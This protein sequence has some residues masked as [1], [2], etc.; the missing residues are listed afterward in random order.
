MHQRLQQTAMNVN[1]SICGDVT[2]HSRFS[3]SSTLVSQSW[4]YWR[5]SSVCD[6]SKLA[7]FKLINH[8][9]QML[10]VYCRSVPQERE[11]A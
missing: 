8:K 6:T 11:M 9:I 4:D 5:S 3:E 1:S 7:M 10:L 2:E